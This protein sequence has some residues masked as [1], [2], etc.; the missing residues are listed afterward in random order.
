MLLVLAI[1]QINRGIMELWM[2][3]IF[4]AYGFFPPYVFCGSGQT[5]PGQ[6]PPP[7]E[8]LMESLGTSRF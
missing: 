2:G 6:P 4:A 1:M 5:N 3:G 8:V 7:P